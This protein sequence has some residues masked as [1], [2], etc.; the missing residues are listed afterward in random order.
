[1]I[2]HAVPSVEHS[3]NRGGFYVQALHRP[4]MWFGP[5]R[6]LWLEPQIGPFLLQH[7]AMAALFTVSEFKV[8]NPA[9]KAFESQLDAAS[10]LIAG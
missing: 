3:E 7:F 5:V 8:A 1:M 6:R 2:S 10:S 4:F 9:A